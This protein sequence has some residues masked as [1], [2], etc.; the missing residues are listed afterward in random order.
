[1]TLTGDSSHS[2]IGWVTVWA[3]GVGA[4]L[5]GDFFGWQFVLYGGFGSAL[6]AVVLASSFYWLYAGMITEMAIRYETSGGAFSFVTLEAPWGRIPA[7]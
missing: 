7:V 2:K 5:G 6:V 1:M 4:T 3:I